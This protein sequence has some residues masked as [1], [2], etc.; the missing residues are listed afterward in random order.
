MTPTEYAKVHFNNV[1]HMAKRIEDSK[2]DADFKQG[3]ASSIDLLAWGLEEMATGVRATYLLLEQV[4]KK[5]D[6]LLTQR[7]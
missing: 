7:R 6:Q 3:L 2:T 1:K 4:N 5:L